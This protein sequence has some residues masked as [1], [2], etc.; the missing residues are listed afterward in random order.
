MPYYLQDAVARIIDNA[1]KFSARGS[2]V[3][4]RTE[5]E[6]NCKMIIVQDAG[7][8][9]EEAQIQHVFEQFLQINREALEQQG[10]GLELTIVN[11][12][13]CSR[14]DFI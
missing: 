14:Q 7:I 4:I 13:I 5:T 9:M 2:T 1:I 12:I 11:H 3:Q 10:V 8:G 6:G